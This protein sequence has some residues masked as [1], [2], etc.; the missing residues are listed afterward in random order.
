M[1]HG[2][3]VA[4]ILSALF[5]ATTAYAQDAAQSS[6]TV[7]APAPATAPKSAA[8]LTRADCSGEPQQIRACGELWVKECMQDWDPGTHMTKQQYARVCRR[9]ANER[10]KFLLSRSK[11]D[12][13]VTPKK[14]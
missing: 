9:V 8:P 2:L 3:T 5:W 13:A 6:K 12:D 7:P 4:S 11:G 10:V 14:K 1:R